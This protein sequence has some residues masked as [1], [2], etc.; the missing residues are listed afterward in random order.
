MHYYIE[1]DG[2]VF[3]IDKD[4]TL[5]LPKSKDEVPFVF[6]ELRKMSLPDVDVM[7]CTAGNEAGNWIHKDDIPTLQAADPLV[8]LAVNRSLVRHVSD[9][10]IMKDGNVLMVKASRG[11][12]AGS[13]DLPGGFISYG[14]S[15]EESLV[16]EVKEETGLDIKIRKFHH[17]HTNI[18]SGLYFLALFY[19]CDITGGTLKANPEEIIEIA[20][21]PLDEA[22]HVSKKDFIKEALQIYKDSL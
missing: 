17:I 12:V 2:L 6:K 10:I 5:T 3:L 20:W 7:Y 9:A 22:I 13:W 4:G 14:E 18:V 15:P 21:K 11:L 1:H 19:I 16:R 8:K